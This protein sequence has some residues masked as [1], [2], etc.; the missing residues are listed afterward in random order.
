[1]SSTLE[2]INNAKEV[3][4]YYT[5]AAS[6]TGAVPVPSASV[7]IVAENGLMIA[8][9]ESKLGQ[10]IDVSTVLA[11]LGMVGTLNVVGRNVFIEGAKLLSWGTGSAWALAALSALGATT[12]GVQTYIIGMLAIE[13]GKNG[14]KKLSSTHAEK[15]INQSKSSYSEFTSEWKDKEPRKPQ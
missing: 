11:S 13:I 6:A 5:L 15:V 7:A 12:A 8:H 2:Q 1:M 9:I 10:E 3:V 4:A 14:G